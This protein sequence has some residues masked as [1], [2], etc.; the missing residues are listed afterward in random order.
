MAGSQRKRQLIFCFHGRFTEFLPSSGDREP[1]F[2]QKVLKSHH[3]LDVLAAVQAL[4]RATLDR[5][6]GAELRLPVAKHM[7][8]H[9]CQLGNFPD[10]KIQFI[11][12]LDIHGP[13]EPGEIEDCLLLVINGSL[14]DLTRLEG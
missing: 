3:Q 12:D 1:L 7:R 4:L 10:F 5:P 8:L 13:R 6:K 9:P 11:R 14:Q 2:V